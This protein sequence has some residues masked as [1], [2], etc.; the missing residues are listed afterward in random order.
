MAL[1]IAA[2]FCL[3]RLIRHFDVRRFLAYPLERNETPS[4]RGNGSRDRPCRRAPPRRAGTFLA[5][6]WRR[7]ARCLALRQPDEPLA[8]QIRREKGL[9]SAETTGAPHAHLEICATRYDITLA[10]RHCSQVHWGC[11]RCGSA[12]VSRPFVNGLASSVSKPRFLA[13]NKSANYPENST[14]YRRLRLSAATSFVANTAGSTPAWML[15][16]TR[17]EQASS[18]ITLISHPSNTVR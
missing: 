15:S 17:S 2:A 4:T 10:Y 3:Q 8:R 7:A 6:C 13:R 11:T 14:P 1:G 16:L 18:K 12:C 9:L 5:Y